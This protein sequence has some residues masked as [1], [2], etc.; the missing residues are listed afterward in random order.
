MNPT[1]P[2]IRYTLTILLGIL[3]GSAALVFYL[4]KQE[5]QR[6]QENVR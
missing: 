4:D 2:L 3:L 5:Q 6:I 1:H